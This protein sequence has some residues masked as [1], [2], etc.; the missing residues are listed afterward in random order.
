MEQTKRKIAP[1]DRQQGENRQHHEAI[2]LE[3]E[4]TGY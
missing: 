2:L 3:N 1:Q 4:R